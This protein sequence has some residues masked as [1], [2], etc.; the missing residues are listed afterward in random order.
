MQEA[1]EKHRQLRSSENQV[2]VRLLHLQQVR[3]KQRLNQIHEVR[4]VE[5][6]V[7]VVYVWCLLC[8]YIIQ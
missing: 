6:C 4:N 8:V 7:T 3:Q 5:H 2:L 1:V